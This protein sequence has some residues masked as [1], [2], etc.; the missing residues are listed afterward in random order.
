MKLNYFVIPL[1]VL[2]VAII[3]SSFTSADSD[4]YKNLNKPSFTPPGWVISA[5]WTTIFA[6][7]AVSLLFVWNHLKSEWF[8]VVIGLFAVNGILNI[9]WSYLFFRLNDVGAAMVEAGLLGFSVYALI[10]ALWKKQRISALLLL[11]YA[12]WVTFATYLTYCIWVLN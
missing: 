7:C 11:P 2:F 1:L 9:F 5:V 10:F 6:L 12:L 8:W 4:W 3:G